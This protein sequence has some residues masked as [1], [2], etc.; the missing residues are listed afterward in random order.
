MRVMLG[1]FSGNTKYYVAGLKLF[2][3][4]KKDLTNV[5][6]SKVWDTYYVYLLIVVNFT[7]SVLQTYSCDS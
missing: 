4:G 2:S 5:F 7:I 6:V 1:A 3:V